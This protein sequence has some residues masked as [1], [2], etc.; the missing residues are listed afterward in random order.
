MQKP[1]S[2]FKSILF[3][4]C[5]IYGKFTNNNWNFPFLK[6]FLYFYVIILT[7]RT[8]KTNGT[9]C[10]TFLEFPSERIVKKKKDADTF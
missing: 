9:F 3:Y 4:I 5:F 1:I 2:E 7:A 10:K 6:I 8:Y